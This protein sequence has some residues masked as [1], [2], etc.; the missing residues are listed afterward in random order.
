MFPK[1]RW[2]WAVLAI[3]FT[4]FLITSVM[5]DRGF[6]RLIRMVK[7]RDELSSRVLSLKESNAHLADEIHQL[8]DDPATIENLARTELGMVR[9]GETVYILNDRPG[10]LSP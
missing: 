1:R 5:G 2:L 8:R 4:L 10:D 9:D 3:T 7:Q 6:I